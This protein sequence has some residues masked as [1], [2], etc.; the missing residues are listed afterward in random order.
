MGYIVCNSDFPYSYHSTELEPLLEKLRDVAAYN[1]EVAPL[2]NTH[3]TYNCDAIYL[4]RQLKTAVEK[5]VVSTTKTGCASNAEFFSVLEKKVNKLLGLGSLDLSEEKQNT[6]CTHAEEG[7]GT[8]Y[9]DM[10]KALDEKK[11]H[12]ATTIERVNRQKRKLDQLTAD[13][14]SN[15]TH[16]IVLKR[17][18]DELQ[19]QAKGKE[20]TSD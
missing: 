16:T 12:I 17:R 7:P 11:E 19:L 5:A 6:T 18:C 20:P 8:N 2:E 14:L 13:T 15:M 4:A 1:R 9:Q 3:V 10:Q